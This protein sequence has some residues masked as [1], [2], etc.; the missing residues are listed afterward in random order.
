[1]PAMR[2]MAAAAAKAPHE[3]GRQFHGFGR[4]GPLSNGGQGVAGRVTKV[5]GNT[6]TLQTRDGQ[7]ATVT[8]SGSTQ[9]RGPGASLKSITPGTTIAAVGT[10][11][12]STVQATFVAVIPPHAVGTVSKIEG[13]TITLTPRGGDGFLGSNVT[14]IVISKTTTF[15][16]PGESSVTA[17]SIKVGDV[18]IATGTLSA[19]G[20]TLQAGAVTIAPSGAVPFGGHLFRHGFFGRGPEDGSG[21][22]GRQQFVSRPGT[23]I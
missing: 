2:I 20:K 16:S 7:T 4:F 18:V 9:Y 15:R 12:G 3:W 13:D 11:S 17:S 6:I 5:D 21:S 8:V 23:T 10:R 1:M 22:W 14:T 19:D